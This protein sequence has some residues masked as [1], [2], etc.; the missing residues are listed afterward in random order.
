[1]SNHYEQE[2]DTALDWLLTAESKNWRRTMDAQIPAA[3]AF[4]ARMRQFLTEEEA[5]PAVRDDAVMISESPP[6]PATAEAVYKVNREVNVQKGPPVMST[7]TSTPPTS[8][9][10][11]DPVTSSLPR[12][13]FTGFAAGAAALIIVA[14]L[15]A[16]FAFTL[17]GRQ[18]TPGSAARPTVTTAKTAAPG[19]TPTPVTQNMATY[20]YRPLV[21]APSNPQIVYNVVQ[22]G[23]QLARSSDGGATFHP[24]ATPPTS[25]TGAI[26]TIMVS[27]LDA[28]HIFAA[29]YTSACQGQGD[30]QRGAQEL[31]FTSSASSCTQDFFSADGGQ[32]WSALALPFTGVIG[33]IDGLLRA[34]SLSYGEH[35]VFYA[36]GSRLFAAAGAASVEGFI[37]YTPGVHLVM[38]S[39]GGA[40][41]QLADNGLSASICDF[42]A[43]PSG[44]TVYAITSPGCG[45]V[46]ASAP[47]ARTL[48]RSDDAGGAWTQVGTLP[49]SYDV[50]ILL[51]PSGALYINASQLGRLKTLVSLDGGR[52][53]TQ[54]PTT[55]LPSAG[56][57]TGPIGV[58]SDGSVVM[59]SITGAYT[60]PSALYAWRSGQ[61]SWRRIGPQYNTMIVWAVI[62]PHGGVDTLIV[63][64]VQNTISRFTA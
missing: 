62:V 37:L 58:L 28:N 50:G 54:S 48:W 59:E 38:S 55:G 30:P 49:T 61:S 10:P 52:S 40:S 14:L 7:P 27:P 33:T 17:H 51:A 19:M 20:D 57:L 31:A 9:F 2:D 21:V 13:G 35:A 34:G 12:R 45:H 8:P 41:W 32:T 25:L 44:A 43:A 29:A 6:H 36:Q 64:D 3:P 63:T 22:H 11:T 46:N 15:A 24:I 1:M 23:A 16:T 18:H 53:F 39:D 47:S 26:F 4:V 42:A 60:A 5:M 56:T